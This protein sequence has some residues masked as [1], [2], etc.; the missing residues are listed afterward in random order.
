M[1]I[2]CTKCAGFGYGSF[3]TA[4]DCPRCKGTGKREIG[5]VNCIFLRFGEY[6]RKLVMEYGE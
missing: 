2:E 5:I 4:T 1:K 6:L 3:A